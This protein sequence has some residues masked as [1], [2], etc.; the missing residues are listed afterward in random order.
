MLV[1]YSAMLNYGDDD[2]I[3]TFPDVPKAFSSAFS[4]DH[5]IEMAK[6]VLEIVL[7]GKK[8]SELPM[9][10]PKEQVEESIKF[11]VVSVEIE[12]GVRNGVLQQ[13]VDDKEGQLERIHYYA[14]FN[15]GADEITV[16]F[17]DVPSVFFFAPSPDSAIQRAKEE[18]HLE[19]SGKKRSALPEPSSK[20]QVEESIK[21][22]VVNIEI[23]MRKRGDVLYWNE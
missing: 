19:L 20:A 13:N 2:I 16:S 4:R 17:P 3:I 23:F 21:Y 18:L 7:H 15:Y 1:R 12:M 10:T 11:E 14:I 9:P 6:E 5:A 8:C 22:E